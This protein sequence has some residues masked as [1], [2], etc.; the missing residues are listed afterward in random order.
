MTVTTALP[1]GRARAWLLAARPRT[2]P[3]AVGPVLVGIGVGISQQAFDPLLAMAC[4]VVAL[5]LQ[6][7]ANLANDLFDHRSGADASDRLGP[8]RA[9]AS[10]LLSE[11]DLAVGTAVCLVGAAL[12]GLLLVAAGG[13]VLLVLGALCMILAVAYTGGPFPYGYRGLGEVA[14]FLTF[15]VLAV[16]GTAYL[17]TGAWSA[18][19]FAAAVPPGCLVTAILVVNN[20][21]DI[22]PDTRARKVTLAVRF[23]ARFARLEYLA[24]LAAACAVPLL[25]VATGAAHVAAL[26]PLL[27][28]PAM[29]PLVR[30]VFAEG[31]PRRLNGVLAGTAN[32]ALA[33]SSLF[34]LGLALDDV[35]RWP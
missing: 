16:A 10:G 1:T 15:G 26:L 25:L 19:A 22:G 21:R 29:A 33:C 5:L 32:L 14:V 13:P 23:G 12:V 4:L 30:T 20:L 8:P 28:V 35:V 3:A 34:A 31:D 2:L 7:A 18:L 9:A 27:A 24:L 17:Q 6:V 11:R